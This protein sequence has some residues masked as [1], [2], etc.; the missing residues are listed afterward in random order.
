M[1]ATSPT[2]SPTLSAMVAGFRGSSSGMPCF[3]LT[4]QVGTDV[5]G[6][7]EDTA[8]DAG[9]QRLA[10]GTHAEAEHRHGDLDQRQ[11]FADHRPDPVQEGE[12]EGDVEQAQADNGQAHHG[13]GAEGDLQAFVER[14]LRRL[15]AV[16][17]LAQVAVFMPNQPAKPEKK[18]PVR[19]ANGTQWHF[20]RPNRRRHA[21]RP[22]ITTKEER[23]PAYHR[24]IVASEDRRWRLAHVAGD[25]L[26][27]RKNRSKQGKN[28]QA[29]SKAAFVRG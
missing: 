24:C 3:D 6:L 1:P 2:L 25:L 29:T 11:R 20:A 4:D 16:R 22:Q 28:T 8:A 10:A 23:P 18:P 9:E 27:G 21:S 13:S 19:K 7:G 5:R 14:L 17:L 26:H 12:P 15:A